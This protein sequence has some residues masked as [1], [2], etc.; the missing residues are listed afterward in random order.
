[1]LT[2]KKSPLIYIAFFAAILFLNACNFLFGSKDDDSV[3]DVLKQGAIDP[4][5]VPNSVGYVPVLPIWRGFDQPNDIFIGYD[6]MVYV[7][8][9]QG[10]HV[11][12]QKGERFRI[13]PIPNASKVTQ[14]RRMILYVCGTA[15]RIINGVSYDLAAVYRI[16]N[17]AT[18]SGYQILDTLV[19]PFNDLSR[20][21]GRFRPTSDP[22]VRFS[23]VAPLADNRFFIARTGP[24]NDPFG[25]SA[26]DNALLLYNDL[27]QN[28]GY[29][30]TLNPSA[31]SLRSIIGFSGISSFI[32]PPQALFGVN[33]TGDFLALQTEQT[34]AGAKAVPEYKVLWIRET[35]NPEIGFE[36]IENPTMLNFDTTKADRFL[37]SPFRF[38]KPVDVCV[39]PDETRYIF[40]VDA[41]KDSLY[42]FTFQGFEGV[43][44]PPS[45]GIRKQII[46]SFGG[47]GDGPFQFNEP[48]G[49]A[50]FRRTVFVSDK[51]NNRIIRYRLSTDLER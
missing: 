49:V 24:T 43:N 19:H 39:A 44:P 48:S 10:V 9:K 51:G 50:Y 7:A 27:G 41:E 36:Y 11:L 8:D 16:S 22:L 4:L 18:I 14:D 6:E 15:Q 1:M 17:P 2:Q 47:K 35:F 42:Q 37:Y 23:G 13:I 32:G 46:A 25:T 5:L 21:T 28:T 45:S 33:Q 29:A 30:N 12:D 34:I 40:L 26:P 3:A 20:N 31:S 38:G